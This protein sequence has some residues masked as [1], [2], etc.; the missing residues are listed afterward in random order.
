MRQWPATRYALELM[1]R[2]FVRT[3]ELIGARWQ[4]IDLVTAE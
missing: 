4:E 2:T 3:S 1:A